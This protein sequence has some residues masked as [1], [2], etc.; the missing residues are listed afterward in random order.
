LHSEII[1]LYEGAV[2]ISSFLQ[3][4]ITE[5]NGLAM[6][7]KEGNEEEKKLLKISRWGYNDFID[8]NMVLK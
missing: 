4:N 7:L 6:W 2:Q 8:E 5:E 1:K 3:L